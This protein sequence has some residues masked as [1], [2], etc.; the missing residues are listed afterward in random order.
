MAEQLRNFPKDAVIGAA[1]GCHPKAA[2]QWNLR[3][4][5]ELMQILNR[6]MD[7]EIRALALGE[8]GLD[9]T[10]DIPHEVQLDA[11]RD[12]IALAGAF[13]LP[14]VLHIRTC[15]TQ[16]LEKTAL[17]E[18]WKQLDRHHDIHF[19]C[20]SYSEEVA[21]RWISVFPNVKF[22]L[23]GMICSSKCR[24]EL[25]EFAANFRL[26][27]ILTESDAPHFDRNKRGTPMKALEVAEQLARL[28]RMPLEEV[29][30]QTTRSAEELYRFRLN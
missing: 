14:I 8:C 29:V 15:N 25:K 7:V 18:L 2:D 11:F 12:Q 16:N 19:H 28:R 23:T 4:Q 30:A 1:Y 26:D 10:T 24:K 13:R 17:E 27:A 21:N 20:F 22:G 6:R 9:N 3:V 5:R